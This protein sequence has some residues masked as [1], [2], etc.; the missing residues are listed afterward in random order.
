MRD[1]RSR[2][3]LVATIG[4]SRPQTLRVEDE[5]ISPSIIERL[6]RSPRGIGASVGVAQRGLPARPRLERVLRGRRDLRR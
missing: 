4:M 5:A 1:K 6:R 2:V 3:A